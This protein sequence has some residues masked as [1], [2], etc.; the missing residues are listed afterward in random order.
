LGAL[1]ELAPPPNLTDATP[2]LIFW[3]LSSSK[4]PRKKSFT[5]E[6]FDNNRGS[7]V[8]SLL[9][10]K[11]VNVFSYASHDDF[12][13][14]L[15]KSLGLSFDIHSLR[16]KATLPKELEQIE[17]ASAEVVFVEEAL[18]D[19]SLGLILG[20]V[21]RKRLFF[22][23]FEDDAESLH[24]C[25]EICER[26]NVPAENVHRVARKKSSNGLSKAINEFCNSDIDREHTATGLQRSWQRA[27]RLIDNML[28]EQTV[29][30]EI[31]ENIV[32]K[33]LEVRASKLSKG[34]F[35]SEMNPQDEF[36]RAATPLYSQAKQIYALNTDRYSTFWRRNSFG[37]EQRKRY[38][39]LCPTVRLFLYSSFES[40]CRDV[41]NLN[42]QAVHYSNGGAKASLLVGDRS[43]FTQL[44]QDSLFNER[45]V[46]DVAFI[47][48][49]SGE[50]YRFELDEGKVEYE[51]MGME[52]QDALL[53]QLRTLASIP[54]EHGKKFKGFNFFKWE[55]DLEKSTLFQHFVSETFPSNTA[56]G[57]H[58][59]ITFRND[60]SISPERFSAIILSVRQSL[61]MLYDY[62]KENFGLRAI[63]HG[64]AS[65][66]NGSRVADGM[67]PIRFHDRN[68]PKNVLILH[69]DSSNRSRSG[70]MIL[71]IALDMD[72]GFRPQ[73]LHE[74]DTTG[75]RSRNDARCQSV[76]PGI[77]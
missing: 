2:F 74:Q 70:A 54:S 8:K 26:F 38:L 14:H 7:Q 32:V 28:E 24:R 65:G 73:Y 1:L 62:F 67:T 5:Q 18:D 42:D 50:W 23:A 53:D 44:C 21:N 4:N 51:K 69:F 3:T 10:K 52:I 41:S 55:R 15:R 35:L 19:L 33:P 77:A 27:R 20:V 59:V 17:P 29:N 37:E 46:E 13:S 36:V 31:V 22:A 64:A 25:S 39:T 30:L 40:L 48:L 66:R 75:T 72:G 16:I 12:L 68:D 11:S 34:K 76:R 61:G 60:G 57:A 47:Q 45:L 71:K 56:T 49:I 58:R 9:S 43:C 63:E 6:E